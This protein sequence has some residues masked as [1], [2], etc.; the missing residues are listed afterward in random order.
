[1]A[2][3]KNMKKA[4]NW[5]DPGGFFHEGGLLGWDIFKVDTTSEDLI[6][7]KKSVLKA[8]LVERDAKV[9]D[10]INQTGTILMYMAV[11]GVIVYFVYKLKEI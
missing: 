8:Q 6:K 3:G 1:M 10:A 7:K 4:A 2:L 9:S 11:V 5:L